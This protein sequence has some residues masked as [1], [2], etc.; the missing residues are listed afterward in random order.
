RLAK[1]SA[2]FCPIRSAKSW[3]NSRR[4]PR[5]H[6]KELGYIQEQLAGC[7]VR[8]LSE[9]ERGKSSASIGKAIEISK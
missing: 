7:G 1:A 5:A 8:Y 2:I 4:H 9:L 3:G 6:R